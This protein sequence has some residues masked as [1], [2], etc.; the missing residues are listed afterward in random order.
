MIGEQGPYF[1]YHMGKDI[2]LSPKAMGQP[3]KGNHPQTATTPDEAATSTGSLRERLKLKKITAGPLQILKTWNPFIPGEAAKTLLLSL[4]SSGTQTKKGRDILLD[5][6][7]QGQYQ[8]PTASSSVLNSLKEE[9]WLRYFSG[10]ASDPWI[11]TGQIHQ[12][13]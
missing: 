4:F 9:E 11:V 12:G 7:A 5:P 13:L 1:P 3:A 6:E 2:S 10:P 8:G